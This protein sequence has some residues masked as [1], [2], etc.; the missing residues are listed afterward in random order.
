MKRM[1]PRAI[2]IEAYAW[3]TLAI[4]VDV[5]VHRGPLQFVWRVWTSMLEAMTTS[6][7]TILKFQSG[8]R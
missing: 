8:D 6:S 2:E 4:P 5:Q 3:S 1:H 7:R